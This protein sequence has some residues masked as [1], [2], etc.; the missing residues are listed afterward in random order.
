MLKLSA[1]SRENGL[2]VY[3]FKLN[4]SKLMVDTII[5]NTSGSSDSVS[6]KYYDS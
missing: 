4:G 3:R 6:V 1:S 2:G 5:S